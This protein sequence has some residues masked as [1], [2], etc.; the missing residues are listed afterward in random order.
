MSKKKPKN[1]LKVIAFTIATGEH[2]KYADKMIKSLRKFH[3]EEELPIE[4]V[5]DEEVEK[6][7]DPHFFYRAT[8]FIGRQLLEKYDVVVKLDADQIITADISHVWKGDFDV[9]VVNNSNPKEYQQ[10]PVSVWN[11]HPLSYVNCGF[12]VMKNIDFTDHWWKL[13]VSPHFNHYQMREQDLLNIMIFYG[14]YKVKFLD[15]L[16]KWHGLVSK[17]Y[18]PKIIMKDGKMVLPD[19]GEWPSDGDKE[20]VC[21]HW[22]GGNQP[23]KMNYK[24][25]FKPEVVKYLDKLVK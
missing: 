15:A 24:I 18:W 6:I 8:P 4:I 12:V 7:K 21:I 25:H 20:I 23:N 5:G 9:A 3:S 1:K 16:G 10:Y 2:R 22:A 13:C 17:G 11:I 19:D 14:N